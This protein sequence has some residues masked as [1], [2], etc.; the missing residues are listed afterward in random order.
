[1]TSPNDVAPPEQRS[2]CR[3][4]ALITL[5]IGVAMVLLLAILII[6]VCGIR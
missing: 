4:A 6:G 3:K 5:G 2:G 1:L